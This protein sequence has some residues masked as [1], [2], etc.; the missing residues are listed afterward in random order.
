V[1]QGFQRCDRDE[2]YYGTRRSKHPFAKEEM[3]MPTPE[4]AVKGTLEVNKQ[5]QD[6][7]KIVINLVTASLVL[8][9]VFL[10]NILGL[11]PAEIKGHLCPMAYISW[12]SLGISL[13]LCIGFY[14][15]STKFTKALYGLYEEK[16]Q[17]RHEK[18]GT[19]KDQT[20][21]WRD[22]MGV[23]AAVFAVVGL[24]SLLIFFVGAL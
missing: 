13:F 7:I 18:P 23:A 1:A 9:I 2:G 19:I 8:P 20:E 10:K 22:W 24:L 17:E 15:F 11:E 3:Q 4:E 6:E 16:E 14:F 5:Y 21:T 12:V